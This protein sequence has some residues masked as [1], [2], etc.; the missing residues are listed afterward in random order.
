MK[1]IFVGV[2]VAVLLVGVAII[3]IDSVSKSEALECLKL[4]DQ[5]EQYPSFFVT[6]WQK[7]MCDSRGL[8]VNA[9]VK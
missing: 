9:P 2:F 7:E 4:Q 6:Q 8:P 5:A 3:F 1:P